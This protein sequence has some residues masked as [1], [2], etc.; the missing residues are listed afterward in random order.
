MQEKVKQC[1]NSLLQARLNLQDVLI[2]Q[3][4]SLSDSLSVPK[5]TM[6]IA[7]VKSGF[8]QAVADLKSAEYELEKA[9]IKAPFDGII[10][11]LSDK[12]YNFPGTTSFCTLINDRFFEAEFKVLENEIGNIKRND[13]V[14]ILPVSSGEPFAGKVTAVNPQVNEKGLVEIKALVENRNGLLFDGMNVNVKVKQEIRNCMV[15]PKSAVVIRS[16]KPV[17]F[18]HKDGKAIWKYVTLGN[19]NS[20]CYTLQPMDDTV[21]EGDEVIYEG[22]VNLAHESPVV[23]NM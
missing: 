9:T 16:G 7:R 17:V 22:V 13:K 12:E 14:E 10:A 21:N 23:I 8:E 3:G 11:N 6:H 15:V 4:Y 19:E 1:S 2:G 5:E 20:S 18:I